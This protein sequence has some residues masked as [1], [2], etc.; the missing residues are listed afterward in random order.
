MSKT[1]NIVGTIQKI[2]QWIAARPWVMFVVLTAPILLYCAGFLMTGNMIAGGDGDYLMQTQEA[3]RRSIL[4]F[5]QFPWWNPW[6]SGG[7][8]LFANP[9]FGLISLI[10]PF[11]LAF[12]AIIG[13]KIALFILFVVGFWGLYLLFRRCFR[14]PQTTAILLAYIWT[15]GTFLAQRLGGGHYTFFMIQLFPWALMYYLRRGEGKWGWLKFGLVTS[16]MTLTAAHNMT[17]M[18]YLVIGLIVIIQSVRFA[19]RRNR[20]TLEAAITKQDVL[21]WLKA[22]ALI[23]ALTGYRLYYTMQYLQDYPRLVHGSEA[24]VGIFKGLLAMFGPGIQFGTHSPSVPQWSWLEASAY[25]GICTFFAL[26]VVT[27]SAL[28]QRRSL[29]RLFSFSPYILS[30]LIVFFFILGLG[31]FVG[32]FSPYILLQHLPILSSMRVAT[33]WFAWCSLSTL[34]VIA[35]YKAPRYRKIINI[36]LLASVIELFVYS[37]PHLAHTYITPF[38][39]ARAASAPFEQKHLYN[40]KRWGVPYDE[41]LT[42][43][44]RDNYGQIIAG[45]SLID[46]RWA[47]PTGVLTKRCSIDQGCNF[48][49]TNNA[50]LTYWSPN[51]IILERAGPG[52]ILLNTNPGKYWMVNGKYIF[53]SLKVVDPSHDF[54]IDNPDKTITIQYLPHYSVEW[55]WKKLTNNL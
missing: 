29:G 2:G 12:G 32:H 31:R 46:T 6:V 25:I 43:A 41:N 28:K 9:Q 51:K 35:A 42:D 44:T 30:G 20:F 23:I 36:L 55:F 21:F 26:M 11:T 24:T 4:E 52:N 7:V 14:T 19:Y 39:H 37:R 40:T 50:K 33:R 54:S 16:L 1:G 34:F 8:P 47:P 27:F 17:I 5:H 22:G 48:V 53:Y 38:D 45:D 49:L 10:T 15:F 18:S 3:M 13:Y